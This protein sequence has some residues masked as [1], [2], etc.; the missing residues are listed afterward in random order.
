MIF[1]LSCFMFVFSTR[2][3]FWNFVFS[4]KEPPHR[5]HSDSSSTDSSATDGPDTESPSPTAKQPPA[6]PLTSDAEGTATPSPAVF[7]ID[8]G[9]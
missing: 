9:N 3:L 2:V 4:T 1:L 7:S 8:L 6:L 5:R